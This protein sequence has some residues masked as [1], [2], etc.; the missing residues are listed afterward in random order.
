MKKSRL[1]ISLAILTLFVGIW[2]LGRSGSNRSILSPPDPGFA[3]YV[4]AYSGGSQSA[5]DPIR[6]VFTL[7]IPDAVRKQMPADEILTLSP[8]A[9]GKLSW[10]DAHTL[11]FKPD[12]PLKRDQVYKVSVALNKLMGISEAKFN[13]FQYQFKVMPQEA[14]LVSHGLKPDELHPNSWKWEGE[15]L[16]ADQTEIKDL[17]KAFQFNASQETAKVEWEH[18]PA[19]LKHSFRITGLKKQATNQT[20]EVALNE[21]DLGGSGEEK[22]ETV[23]HREGD[24]LL[25]E[26]R[27][28][29]F[30]EPYLVASFTEVLDQA[31]M[32]EAV[33]RVAQ[34]SMAKMWIQDNEI[35]IY[36]NTSRQSGRIILDEQLKSA[37]GSLLSLPSSF[38]FDF[39]DRQPALTL[40][41]DG[42]ILPTSEGLLLPFKSINLKSVEARIFRIPDHHM[43]QFLQSNQLNGYQ[44][45]N[46]VGKPLLVRR[47]SLE[48]AGKANLNCWHTYSIDLS[49]WFKAEPGALYRVVLNFSKQDVVCQCPATSD[50]PSWM[51]KLIKLVNPETESPSFTEG[52]YYDEYYSDYGDGYD[53]SKRDDPCNPAFY[54]G[55]RNHQ[56][57]NMLVSDIGL[58]AKKDASGQ[59]L[60][61]ATQ[62]RDATPMS[63]V[64]LSLR[65]YQDEIIAEGVTDAEG[66]CW[67]KA[68]RQPYYLR[69]EHRQ[70]RAFLRV[71]PSSVQSVG[72]FDVSGE[73]I[74]NGHKG[75]LY[76]E[77]GVWRPGDSLFVGFM[78][79][80]SR[81]PLPKGFPIVFE[82][83]NPQDQVIEREVLSWEKK[84][85]LTFRTATDQDAV[86]G[87]W[88]VKAKVGSN[89][90]LKRLRI[91][92]IKPNR[93][94]IDW[95]GAPSLISAQVQQSALQLQ[96][97][98]LHGAPASGLNAVVEGTFIPQPINFKGHSGF[99]FNPQGKTGTSASMVLFTGALSQT[100]SATVSIPPVNKSQAPGMMRLD[101]KTR[102]FEPGGEASIDAYS[103][104][105]SPYPAY[106]GLKIPAQENSFWLEVNKPQK[107]ELLVVNPQGQ[108]L[109]SRKN[110]R[111]K[112]KKLEW[113][114]W[115]QEEE[116]ELPSFENGQAAGQEIVW[117]VA[118]TQ[119]RMSTQFSFPEKKW[120]RYLLEVTDIE[121]GHTSSTTLYADDGSG[122]PAGEDN[123]W[124][125]MLA[126][127]V[128]KPAYQSGDEIKISVPAHQGRV[129]VS[130]ENGSK[131]VASFWHEVTEKNRTIVFK[132]TP[133]MS[134]MVYAHLTLL[135][136]HQ[137]R[138]SG[139]PIRLFGIKPIAIKDPGSVLSPK[140]KMPEVLKPASTYEV[141]ISEVSGK[142]MSYTLAIVDEGLLGLTRFKTPDP[143]T[144]LHEK[145]ALGVQTWDLYDWVSSGFAGQTGVL[146]GTG[147][148]GAAL[149]PESQKTN[150]FAPVVQFLG[151]FELQSGET[152]KHRLTMPNYVGAV[153][154]M[155][156]ATSGLAQ[157]SSE[158]TVPVKQDLMLMATMPRFVRPNDQAQMGVTLFV[159]K[160]IKSPIRVKA[161]V[162]GEAAFQGISEQTIVPN[163]QSEYQLYFP[164]KIGRKMGQAELKFEANSGTAKAYYSD[165]IKI[166]QEGSPVRVVVAK[167]ISPNQSISV[168]PPWKDATLIKASLSFSGTPTFPLTDLVNEMERYPHR[169]AEQISSVAMSRLAL[170]QSGLVSDKTYQESLI[171][172]IKL[173][174]IQIAKYQTQEGQFGLWPKS[175]NAD[176]WVSVL[177]GHS[178]VLAKQ[179][180][181]T[182]VEQVFNLWKDKNRALAEQFSSGKMPAT[183]LNTQAYRLM[184]LALAGTPVLPAMSRLS[185]YPG[186]PVL[187]RHLLGT[188]F[189]LSGRIQEARRLVSVV[190]PDLPVYQEQGGS[191]GSDLRDEALMLMSLQYAGVQSSRDLLFRQL[192]ARLSSDSW[193]STHALSLAI[194]VLVREMQLKGKPA[195]LQYS[196]KMGSQEKSINTASTL[197]TE[198]LPSVK[199]GEKVILNNRGKAPLFVQSVFKGIRYAAQSASASGLKLQVVFK[200]KSGQVMPLT[201][202]KRGMDI[203]AE[204]KVSA[205]GATVDFRGM[206]L[207]IP[208]AAGLEMLDDPKGN[209]L[210]WA[211]RRDDRTL[212]YFDL[213]RAKEVSF[214]TR[215]Q[216]TYSGQF[217]W[218][219]ASVESMY[220]QAWWARIADRNIAI[221]P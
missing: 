73:G 133:E 204:W 177:V 89:E 194:W 12:K 111:I 128:E 102:V 162:K 216:L 59:W 208:A 84:P 156:V 189:A 172:S 38:D 197:S 83:L 53:W 32:V 41:G 25:Q 50:E 148:D 146:V 103:I 141:Q 120:G 178:I 47:L 97:F 171:R 46:R 198:L 7:D 85:L 182:P 81:N 112:L 185:E 11:T 37:S 8:S 121:G 138:E 150:R 54:D 9:T 106:V 164:L 129:F 130:L 95:P 161:T 78:L 205:P 127:N 94:R 34:E 110:L 160:K 114:W 152:A 122:G 200:N 123:N 68:L 13:T 212:I 36:P 174:L 131:V 181:Y 176:A 21:D 220:D 113:R 119:G 207:K 104:D 124:A 26:V 126:F 56:A 221:A 165:D 116:E 93:L 1:I 77:R 147:G 45:L 108:L 72:A 157:G 125:S 190:Q 70:Q 203:L 91:E 180:G 49:P 218:P 65:S 76:T 30:P 175:E 55:N 33:C 28:I 57:R 87:N 188:A 24:F 132:A 2:I 169:C 183:S 27:T 192:A 75:F 71:D 82:L 187:S 101:L 136:P 140:I 88:R 135:Q 60:L 14:E 214:Q 16:L 63:G 58:M 186:L 159:D 219:G 170:L 98:W 202:F 20:L 29:H 166:I 210:I 105:Y 64:K 100:G 107:L 62:L 42:V 144:A 151:P 168:A 201:E 43:G 155:V 163:G 195:A 51:T 35:V 79:D 134:P 18:D 206:A 109:K 15:V 67:I 118:V 139:L 149:S 115:W 143:W 137:K 22:L 117:E 39:Q 158:K 154:L 17:E 99:E 153:R 74:Q 10:V 66:K 4:S 48:N 142:A 145:E 199:A 19:G 3:Q 167:S 23:L 217:F 173:Y 215:F 31:Q 196:W 61:L 6:C 184:V 92:A 80:D 213:P 193:S 86:T 179:A 191:W 90:Y 44:E 96:S 5:Y 52:G 40:L 69:A 209:S 211:D